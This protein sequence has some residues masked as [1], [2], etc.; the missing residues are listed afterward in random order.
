[1]T[2]H[3]IRTPHRAPRAACRRSLRLWLPLT[4]LLATGQACARDAGASDE[5]AGPEGGAAVAHTPWPTTGA[6]QVGDSI[7]YR[8]AGT[9]WYDGVVAKVG[10]D[11]QSPGSTAESYLIEGQGW[12]DY[13]HVAGRKREPYWTGFFVGDWEVSVPVAM[14]TKVIDS[15]L[16]RVVSGGMRLPPL[17]VNPDG[18]Y[19]WRVLENGGERV[20][21]GRWEPRADAPGIILRAGEQ[22][23]DWEL[24]NSTDRSA[25]RT[26]GRTQI[27]L[28]AECCTAQTAQRIPTEVPT[29]L[30]AGDRI[31]E[32]RENGSYRL[33]TVVEVDGDRVQFRDPYLGDSW[34]AMTNLRKPEW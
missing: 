5:S 34:V 14:N 31:I 29:A 13:Q 26:F 22:G 25:R 6:F 3:P 16:Y 23:A 1:M 18:T 4:L 9:L 8:A 11:P 10:P 2:T 17:R 24:Y 21:R 19:L 30:Q 20:I 7:R 15:D 12:Y 32:R 28:T 33:G 27:Y